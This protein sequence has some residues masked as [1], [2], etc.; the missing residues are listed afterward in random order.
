MKK[1][2]KLVY[3]WVFN[4]DILLALGIVS[5]IPKYFLEPEWKG[6]EIWHLT[7]PPSS[8][9]PL[10]IL[11]PC[12]NFQS[13]WRWSFLPSTFPSGHTA[14]LVAQRKTSSR[15]F[16]PISINHSVLKIQ[17]R[18]KKFQLENIVWKNLKSQISTAKFVNIIK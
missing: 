16:F 10:V 6:G 9:F 8:L 17:K 12:V 3:G 7:P 18:Q 2:L 4:K 13:E 11:Q 14:Y 5:S 15:G 1:S